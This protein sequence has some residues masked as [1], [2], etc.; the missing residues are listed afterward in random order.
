MSANSCR[1]RQLSPNCASFLS[2][3]ARIPSSLPDYLGAERSFL[4]G[5]DRPDYLLRCGGRHA[6]HFG[7]RGGTFTHTAI[8]NSIRGQ[9]GGPACGSVSLVQRET[10]RILGYLML[11]GVSVFALL[12]MIRPQIPA[13]PIGV[14]SSQPAEIRAIFDQDCYSCHS[15]Q[16]RLVWFDEIVPAYWLVRYDIIAARERLNFSTLGSSPR[17]AQTAALFEAVNFMRAGAMPPSR[18]TA[19][20]PEARLT[21]D[22]VTKLE[23]Y[24]APWG[25]LPDPAG[26]EDYSG[27]RPTVVKPESN[28]FAYDAAYKNWQPIS[29]TDRGDNN[30]FRMILG[31]NV[32]I[33]AV[34]AG[35]VS[36]WPDGTRLAKIA[37]RQ[38]SG[39]GG[40]IYPGEFV[41]VEFMSKDSSRYR[42]TQG[43][44]W[45]RWRGVELTP[46]GS[47][48]N[49]VNECTGCH[50][51]MR[52]HDHVYTLP[53]APLPPGLPAQVLT[54]NPIT[55]Y[56][57]RSARTM[58]TLFRNPSGSAL[59]L[60]TW[61]QRNDPRWFGARIPEAPQSVEIVEQSSNRYRRYE[62]AAFA[63]G[64]AAENLAAERSRF[65]QNLRPAI[66]P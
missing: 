35:K 40:L 26:A 7:L 56:A 31:N 5:I 61:A 43:W 6:G 1:Y 59:A 41:Q 8:G 39:A 38:E 50:M 11:G 24:L 54:W 37:W 23:A 14:E 53:I 28:G 42:Q 46:Y 17:A 16:R 33:E 45:G 51:P 62:G 66:L 25:T 44:D 63:E 19:L 13:T 48:A 64:M 34:R 9:E 10:M 49:F 3:E 55:M 30:T 60:V 58:A 65:I 2:E 27:A 21:P 22:A 52:D 57:D 20:H 29:F 47:G 18:F 36:P 4:A 12:Q 32:A 15:S